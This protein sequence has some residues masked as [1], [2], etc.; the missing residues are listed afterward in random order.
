MKNI[1][2]VVSLILVLFISCKK[3]VSL[4]NLNGNTIGCFGHAGMG[5]KSVYPANTLQSFE[6]CLNRGADGTEMDIQVTK[7]GVLVIYHNNDLS[8]ATQCGGIIR[9]LNWE[10]INACRFKSSISDNFDVISFDEFFQTL[11]NPYKYT[12]TFD[13]KLTEGTGDNNEYYKTFTSAIISTAEKY[14]IQ[15]N[16]F[17]E[18]SD[19]GFLSL[20]KQQNNQL[21]LFL[22]GNDFEKD[23][24]T[25]TQNGFYGIS[26]DNNA[27]SSNQIKE[28]HDNNI[29]ITIY[30]V[31]TNKENYD[32][33]NKQPDFIQTDDLDYVLK[34]FGKFNRYSGR[35]SDLLKNIN[36]KPS[37]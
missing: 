33:I 14:G 22:L 4:S 18:N 23:L 21:K 10:E 2:I 29:R 35:L 12:F 9:D 32:A 17:I 28:A 11:S 16:L 36:L 34:L 25:V 5:S 7:D 31:E 24:V 13:C 19:A 26:C 30:G 1:V 15:N 37:K 27:I 3:E 8:S 20:I 6:S